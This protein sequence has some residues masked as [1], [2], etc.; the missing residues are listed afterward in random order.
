MASPAKKPVVMNLNV[1]NLQGGFLKHE[2]VT[3]G[4][5][6][7]TKDV[8]GQLFVSIDR[9][10]YKFK[11]FLGDDWTMVNHLQ[12][13]RNAKVAQFMKERLH[14]DDILADER[15]IDISNKK[16]SFR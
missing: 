6:L 1:V 15:L 12:V 11:A 10:S 3:S 13:L 4:M 7:P 2:G 9:K 16:R 14:K 5:T 8:N